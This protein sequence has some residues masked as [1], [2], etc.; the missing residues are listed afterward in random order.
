MIDGTVNVSLEPVITLRLLGPSGQ[1]KEV[2]AVVAT[3]FKRF[4]TLPPEVVSELGLEPS[5][6][7]PVVLPDGTE[8]TLESYA[9]TVLWD[10]EPRD[11]AAEMSPIGAMVGQSL[12]AGHHVLID[13][14]RAGGRVVIE[15]KA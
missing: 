7:V 13:A 6:R 5:G 15:G 10:G 9:V 4:L 2:A 3:G 1:A 8:V 12:L 11:V 14:V